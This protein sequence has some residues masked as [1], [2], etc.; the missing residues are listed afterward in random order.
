[1]WNDSFDD[2]G[3]SP[4]DPVETLLVKHEGDPVIPGIKS[5]TI[6]PLHPA[7]YE[8]QGEKK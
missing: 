1:M 6:H 8:R 3:V 4:N 7:M 2:T 5:L